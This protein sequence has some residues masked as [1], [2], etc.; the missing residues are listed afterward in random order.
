MRVRQL[1]R[2][3]TVAALTTLLLAACG[4]TSVTSSTAAGSSSAASSSSAPTT[5]AGNGEAAK[6]GQQV[7]NDAAD[8]LASAGAV[9]L[10]G[11]GTDGGKPLNLDLHL[12]GTDVSGTIS[13]AGQALDVVSTGGKTYAKA[14]ASFW[15]SQQVPASVAKKLDG[16]WVLLPA[17]AGSAFGD[18]SLTKLADDL[19]KP[20][21]GTWQPQVQ[22]STYEGKDVVIITQTDGST[23]TVAG[24]GTPYPLRSEAKGTDP[25]TVTLS[26]FGKKTTITAPAGALDL[27]QLAGG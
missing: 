27:T 15:T 24:A 9:H 8:A 14:P 17:G 23:T 18:V 5:P 1:A 26:D 12:Q 19:R 3:V 11:S 10:V 25:G 16:Q 13:M 2:H 4:G 6:T 21:H 20:E 22:K 7:A